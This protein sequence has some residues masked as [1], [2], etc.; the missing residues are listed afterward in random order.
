MRCHPGRVTGQGVSWRRDPRS[1]AVLAVSVLV[2]MLGVLMAWIVIDPESTGTVFPDRGSATTGETRTAPGGGSYA[3]LQ[4]QADGETPVAYDPCTPV[5]IVVNERRAPDDADAVLRRAVA[6][7]EDASGLDL[8]V[9]GTTTDPPLAHEDD[10]EDGD[11]WRPVQISWT[12]AD[13]VAELEGRVGGLGGSTWVERDD[14]RTYVT[15]EIMLD[16]PDLVR[17]GDGGDVATGVLMHEL[18]HVLGLDHVDDL[19]EL[20][21]PS[22]PRDAWGPGDRVGLAALGAVDCA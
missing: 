2:G 5:R 17:R 3:F 7:V 13:E 8:Q 12:D 16:A 9:V 15:G 20:M 18:A 1:R 6:E 11:G 10:P 14:R 4:T 22:S 19:G 21:H